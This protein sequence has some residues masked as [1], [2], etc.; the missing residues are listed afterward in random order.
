MLVLSD[1]AKYVDLGTINYL[2][3]L[4]ARKEKKSKGEIFKELGINREALY[5]QETEEKQ[6]VIEEAF[7]RLDHAVVIKALY[8][9]MKIL[10][11]NFIVDI[12]SVTADEINT[13]NDLAELVEEVLAEN[14]ELLKDVRDF[15]RRGIIEFV[16]S[17]LS[18]E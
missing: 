7:K 16:A 18:L 15:D 17:K 14:A 5:K 9:R 10:F 12:L 1:Y 2:I 13:N 11:I 8:G 3:D 6:K 4:I